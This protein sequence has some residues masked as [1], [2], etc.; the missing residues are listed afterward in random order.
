M[1]M[2]GRKEYYYQNICNERSKICSHK[3]IKC[4]QTWN[5][6][7]SENLVRAEVCEILRPRTQ[8]GLRAGFAWMTF[9]EATHEGHQTLIHIA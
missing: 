3:D 9:S 7:N 2:Q 5:E 6:F 1:E 4:L 8:R